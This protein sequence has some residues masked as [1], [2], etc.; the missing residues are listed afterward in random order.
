MRTNSVEEAKRN[1]K[2]DAMS[3]DKKEV[4]KLAQTLPVENIGVRSTNIYEHTHRAA[5]KHWTDVDD[6][7]IEDNGL[8]Q[9]CLLF[10]VAQALKDKIAT[11]PSGLSVRPILPDI[12]FCNKWGAFSERQ[13]VQKHRV[14]RGEEEIYRNFR[15][16]WS[17]KGPDK[18]IRL[19]DRTV[20][21]IF[22]VQD[23]TPK[24]LIRKGKPLFT[25]GLSFHRAFAKVI[26]ITDIQSIRK[27]PDDTIVFNTPIL[28]KKSDRA[29]IIANLTDIADENYDN[30]ALLGFV[31]EPIGQSQMG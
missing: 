4:E 25:N 30:L 2:K 19:N 7:L 9:T 12:D 26:E 17:D 10:L 28:Y 21:L 13:W 31:A 23:L 14:S 27:A 20:L 16:V 6:F 1:L 11:G 5:L 8:I 24:A 29:Q 15:N 3:L 18:E 22:G